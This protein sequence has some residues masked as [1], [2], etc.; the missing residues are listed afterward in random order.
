MIETQ[1][2][3]TVSD[4]SG[5]FSRNHFLEGG[6]TFQWG[7]C[8]SGGAEGFIYKVSKK[9]VGLGSDAPH[10][11]PPNYIKLFLEIVFFWNNRN[12]EELPFERNFFTS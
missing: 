5:F 1:V 8:F 2:L 9:I 10:A 3:M 7:V 12:F 6:F 4:F 11:L